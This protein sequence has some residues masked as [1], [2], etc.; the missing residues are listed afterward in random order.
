MRMWILLLALTLTAC[1]AKGY[2]PA[3]ATNLS[4]YMTTAGL[5]E[6]KG[7][8][9]VVAAFENG[10]ATQV[11]VKADICRDAAVAIATKAR[12]TPQAPATSPAGP[13]P[14]AAVPPAPPPAAAPP[15]EAK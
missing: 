11:P 7:Q 13:P 3:G 2:Q 9:F 8:C 12:V 4:G 10:R 14:P 5:L 1:A 15:T 6:L